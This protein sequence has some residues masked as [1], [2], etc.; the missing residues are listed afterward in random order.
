MHDQNMK[1]D[2]MDICNIEKDLISALKTVVCHGVFSKDVDT[3]ELGELVDMVKDMA[4]TKRNCMEAH[5][6]E[7]VTKAMEEYDYDDEDSMGYNRNRYANGRYAPSGTGNMSSGYRPHFR[8][9]PNRYDDYPMG[10]DRSNGNGNGGNY[11][12]GNGSNSYGYQYGKAYDEYR[13]AK[14][15]YTETKS[16]EDKSHMDEKALEHVN[17]SVMTLRDIWKSADPSVKKDVRTSIKSLA[18]EF[19]SP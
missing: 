3:K 1:P 5:Y 12:N 17:A 2:L 13:D 14:R 6:Y 8:M 19:D 9:M 11:N 16:Y 15:H 4:E 18:E 10:Y 7:T